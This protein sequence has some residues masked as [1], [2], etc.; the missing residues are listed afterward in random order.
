VGIRTYRQVLAGSIGRSPNVEVQAVLI[1]TAVRSV[2]NGLR[3][4]RSVGSSIENLSWLERALGNRCLPSARVELV[5]VVD[6]S[7]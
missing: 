1:L 5:I 3:A 7:I 2:A 4:S 6:A